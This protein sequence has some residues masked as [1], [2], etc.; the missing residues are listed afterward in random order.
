M[1]NM[2][3]GEATSLSECVLVIVAGQLLGLN[4]GCTNGACLS[5][6]LLPYPVIIIGV[7]PWRPLRGPT[8]DRPCNS[9]T[10][11]SNLLAFKC[12]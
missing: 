11:T 1:A 6:F 12:A 9:P 4:S 3:H 8:R 7:K 2:L 10:A 5:G